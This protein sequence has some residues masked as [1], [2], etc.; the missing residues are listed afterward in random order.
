MVQI[1][2]GANMPGYMTLRLMVMVRNHGRTCAAGG[3]IKAVQRTYRV[4]TCFGMA[5]EKKL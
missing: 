4:A 3:P 1:D 5:P 2:V